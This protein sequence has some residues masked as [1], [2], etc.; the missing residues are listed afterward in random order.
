MVWLPASYWRTH[1]DQLTRIARIAD[2]VSHVDAADA[3]LTQEVNN[4]RSCIRDSVE[5]R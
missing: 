1:P 2:A 3:K 5:Q 4:F